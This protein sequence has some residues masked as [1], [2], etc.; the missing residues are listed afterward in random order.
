VQRLGAEISAAYP[1]GVLLVAVLKGSVWFLADLLR[2]TTVAAEVDFMAV[3]SYAPDTG[4][5]RILKDLDS[6]ICGRD[7]VLV[8]DIVDTGLTLTYLLGEL[9][10]RQPTSL[11][12]CA[13]LDKSTRRIVPTRLR[14]VGFD[15]EDAFALGSGLDYAG[16]YRNLPR[17]VAGDLDALRADP[18]AHV[19]ELFA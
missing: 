16:R 2:A 12:V 3:S 6:D 19:E 8:E 17:V 18:E 7:V 14:F 4:R 10:R 11:E 5:V 1:R 9:A 13:L 15:I